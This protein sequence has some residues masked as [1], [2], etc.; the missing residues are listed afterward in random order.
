[1]GARDG[2]AAETP[3]GVSFANR[4][5]ASRKCVGTRVERARAFHLACRVAFS[6]LVF[7]TCA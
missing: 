6:D 4:V 5:S 3:K 1:M 2:S 7:L